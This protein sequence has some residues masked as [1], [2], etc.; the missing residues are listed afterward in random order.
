M[1]KGRSLIS[2]GGLVLES[3]GSSWSL[4]GLINTK[5]RRFVGAECRHW[6]G[7]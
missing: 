7:S 4:G 3:G 5:I 2:R 6:S 1:V